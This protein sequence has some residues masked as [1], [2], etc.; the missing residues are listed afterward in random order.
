MSTLTHSG[1]GTLPALLEA[2]LR[3]GFDASQAQLIRALDNGIWRLTAGIIARVHQ[4]GT[5]DS[6]RTEIRGAYWLYGNGIPVSLPR[7]PEPVVA[8]GRPVTFWTDLGPGGPAN[9][10][11][12]ARLLRTLHNLPAAAD[13]R[14][15]S[16][17]PFARF[18]A[19]IAAAHATPE[20][21]DWLTAHASQLRELWLA[22]DWPTPRC[23]I[24]GD[25]GPGNTTGTTAGT[26]LIDWERLSIGH[27]EWDQA[28]AAWH[29]DLFG[30]S[31]DDYTAFAHVYGH[32]I[33]TW[34]GYHVIRDIRSLCATL[35]A[36]RHATVSPEVRAEADH[37][38][39]CLRRT[40]GPTPK[41]WIG[42]TWQW[43]RPAAGAAGR[44]DEPTRPV[45]GPLNLGIPAEKPVKV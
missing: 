4:P 17:D 11:D 8:A 16:H 25:A 27:R 15:P 13:L 6:A 35:F 20:E 41:P 12:A 44:P 28:T 34:P 43:A 30:A 37:R 32:D 22:L 45:P 10:A 7:R 3:A 38:L 21:K 26:F 29:R 36:L 18:R 24:H 39:S 19:Q 23:V 14:L 2:C 9:P 40:A 33:T 1:E 31:S 5:I 42:R